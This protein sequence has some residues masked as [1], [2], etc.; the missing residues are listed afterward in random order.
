MSALIELL[1]A[2]AMLVA[3]LS[4]FNDAFGHLRR[5]N[6]ALSAFHQQRYHLHYC[7]AILAALANL[8]DSQNRLLALGATS[9]I[10]AHAD[11]YRK[12]LLTRLHDIGE[13]LT[14]CQ[15][16]SFGGRRLQVY[17]QNPAE[18]S[19]WPNHHYTL[20]RYREGDDG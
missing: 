10:A 7:G 1:A 2:A 15:Q 20:R 5:S 16:L 14:S 6:A 18:P 19:H 9:R 11:T 17:R 13:T 8:A 3:A 4:G 12:R